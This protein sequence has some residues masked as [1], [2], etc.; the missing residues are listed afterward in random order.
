MTEQ[1]AT[2]EKSDLD[3][4]LDLKKTKWDAFC[5]KYAVRIAFYPTHDG[6]KNIPAMWV[7]KIQEWV[8][9]SRKQRRHL[10][11]KFGK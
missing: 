7:D 8:W 11:R 9:I 3:K 1:L 10:E 6:R 2:E 4:L 5:K